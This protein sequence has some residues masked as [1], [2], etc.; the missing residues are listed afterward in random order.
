MEKLRLLI[1][2]DEFA[3][4]KVSKSTLEF[5][6]LEADLTDK[7]RMAQVLSRL[8]GQRLNLAGFAS[9]LKVRAVEAK[10][11]FPSKHTWDSFF[12]D[13]KHM[14]ELK[15]GERPDTIYISGLPVKWFSEDGGKTPSELLCMKIFKKWGTIRHI[16]VPAADP[17]RSRMRLDNNINKKSNLNDGIFFDVYVQYVEYVD[18][19]KLMDSLRGMKV[20]KKEDNNYLTA[21]VKV[22]FDKTKH[23]S[24]N[25]VS[26]REFER[27]RL[28]A[29]DHMAMEKLRKREEAEAKKKEEELKKEVADKDAKYMRR[30]KREEK[31]KRKALTIFR[32]QEEDK[33]SM[34][35]ARE[36]QKLI[37]AQRQ[38][39][40]IRLL[41]ELFDRIKIK[42]EKGEITIGD[43]SNSNEKSKDADEKNS[44]GNDK[45]EKKDKKSKK[46]KSKKVKKKKKKDK[47][48]VTSSSDDSDEGTNKK[49]L[50]S[51]L[52]IKPDSY[53]GASTADQNMGFQPMYGQFPQPWFYDAAA[54]MFPGRMR[55][56]G[57]DG[58]NPMNRFFRGRGRGGFSGRRGRPAS[59][60]TT[61]ITPGL[62]P[63]RGPG[64]GTVTGQDQDQD[65]DLDLDPVRRDEGVE[66]EAKVH[67]QSPG[68]DQGP[69][70]DPDL[71]LDLDLDPNPGH[72]DAPSQDPDRD[73]GA[74][75]RNQPE[76]PDRTREIS[77][78]PRARPSSAN[79]AR[80][81]LR[82]LNHGLCR[83]K[84]NQE[85]SRGHFLNLQDNEAARGRKML[86][87]WMKI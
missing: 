57:G 70:L 62:G 23:M 65:Q 71:D 17:Y 68:H 19:V 44:D 2:P 56:R 53:P 36:E 18:F 86:T 51:A 11:D 80:L 84:G 21:I 12:R 38:L 87:M 35:I 45:S 37:K 43:K 5:L 14:N 48:N 28:I 16:D 67:D 31:R 49:K 1:R 78:D 55:G 59:T 81:K 24:D 54:M 64:R 4:L 3:S 79:I 6:R 60:T 76:G 52:A 63:S 75:V 58:A 66:V 34:K 69:G 85:A 29:Q 27:K 15:P 8:E 46:K 10:D 74:H 42:L 50:K 32:K 9:I 82:A 7:C 30:K 22:D 26:R 25:S 61:A 33:V 72:E 39:E 13:A 73:P 83:L 20:L 40:S 47:K 77:S 41:D